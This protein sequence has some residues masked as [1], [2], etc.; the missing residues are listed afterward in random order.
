MGTENGFGIEIANPWIWVYMKRGLIQ[1][2]Q[3]PTYPY[4]PCVSTQLYGEI[5]QVKLP[6]W[7][8]TIQNS[9]GQ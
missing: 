2:R 8:G 6:D 3:V 5:V 1:S 4:M 9:S 7:V